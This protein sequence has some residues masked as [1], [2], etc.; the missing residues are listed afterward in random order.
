MKYYT[1][2]KGGINIEKEDKKD[3]SKDRFKDC[4][5]FSDR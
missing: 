1:L 4:R 2:N 3:N 5:A